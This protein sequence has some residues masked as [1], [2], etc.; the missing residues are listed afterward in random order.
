[1]VCLPAHVEKA[2]LWENRIARELHG[3]L[4]KD[5]ADNLKIQNQA[6]AQLRCRLNIAKR[7]GACQPAKTPR[8]PC[9]VA[10]TNHFAGMQ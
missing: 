10:S 1:M 7:S 9:A 4:Q 8:S 2:R 5:A 6:L 3:G